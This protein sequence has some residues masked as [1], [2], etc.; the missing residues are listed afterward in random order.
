MDDSQSIVPERSAL[1]ELR[2]VQMQFLAKEDP[3]EGLAGSAGH[4]A[5][6]GRG[7][8][9]PPTPVS[10][11]DIINSVER[12]G[13]DT[14]DQAQIPPV[15]GTEPWTQVPGPMLFT[16][17][18]DP[19]LGP[20]T[21][22]ES[23]TASLATTTPASGAIDRTSDVDMAFTAAALNSALEPGLEDSS[24]VP[25]TI[26][27]SELL[28]P[29]T[30]ST[31][32][33]ASFHPDQELEATVTSTGG[34]DV[35]DTVMEDGDEFGILPSESTA[36]NEYI[37]ALPPPARNRAEA[38]EMLNKTYRED[39]E[40][41][42]TAF[43]QNPFLSPD[44]KVVTMIDLMLQSLAE[45]SNLP[46]YHKDLAG[47]SQESWVRYA[48]DTCSKMAFIYEF[49][50]S[51]RTTDVEI[52]ILAA[53]GPM[54]D[55]IEAIVSHGGL[56]YSRANDQ[57]RVQAPPGQGS[58]CKVVLVDTTQGGPNPRLTANILIAYDESAETSG[59]LRPYKTS[60]AEDQIPLIF[61]LM[62][63]YSLEQINRRLSPNLGPLEKKLAQVRCLVSLCRYV[64]DEGAYE[65]VPQPHEVALELV[66]Y[67]VDENSFQPIELRW[68]TWDHQQ[69]PEDVFDAYKGMRMQMAAYEGRK[70][71][72]GDSDPGEETPKRARLASPEDEVQL[73]E[74]LKAR[75]G[76]DIR[77]K[78]G[79]AQ[80]SI[81]KL[82]N[83][84]GLVRRS[85]CFA[86]VWPQLTH[87][88]GQRSQSAARQER[89]T[90]ARLREICSEVPAQI[91][92]SDRGP[93]QLRIGARQG[94]QGQGQSPKGA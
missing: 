4:N 34:P 49:L 11:S 10:P 81:D 33:G 27:P 84:I 67:L 26:T 46:A 85:S 62:E 12:D 55:R 13:L 31:L 47:L 7:H 65:F 77:V 8:N 88:T 71:A 92:R 16:G 43:T 64:D 56:T 53:P 42:K 57:E 61:S 24:H 70:R 73:S 32:P 74:D 5:G 69:I 37:I 93:W 48:R 29:T 54:M 59:I 91:P 14:I 80:V 28:A 78:D 94:H 1:D 19:H 58:A 90:G 38:F 83:L 22:V 40:K 82:E 17:P 15:V 23:N 76:N 66:K 44:H 50:D 20:S 60:R 6:E 2:A 35:P 72:R 18:L 21:A 89:R 9:I 3:L 75:L 41:F 87:S 86:H 36:A 68:N 79:M 30:S 25:A 45:M 52:A 51:L 39:I 63:V